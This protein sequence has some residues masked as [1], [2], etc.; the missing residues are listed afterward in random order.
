MR[1]QSKN[2]ILLTE[3]IFV[4]L[5]FSLV[6]MVVVQMFAAAH[7]LSA[8][9]STLERALTA[10]QDWTERITGSGNMRS[11]MERMGFKPEGGDADPV[12]VLAYNPAEIQEGVPS[13]EGLTI[14]A[15]I[16]VVMNGD[17]GYLVTLL[18]RVFE[19]GGEEPLVELP[20]LTYFPME[21][22]NL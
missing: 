10:A 2:D 1:R 21:L 19:N 15:S 5:V 7:K 4:I 6:A 13:H 8:G 17:A 16:G 18:M 11:Y 22:R 12:Y 20:A 9:S 3:L 14:K